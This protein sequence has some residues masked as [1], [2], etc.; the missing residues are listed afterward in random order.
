MTVYIGYLMLMGIQ[1]W[2]FTKNDFMFTAKNKK[3]FLILCC[4]ELILLAAV[5]GYTV[6]ADTRTYLDALEY[7]SA[8]PKKE[9]LFAKLLW[10]YSFEPG[11]FLFTKICAFLSIPKPLFLLLVAVVI[12]VPVFMNMERYSEL[13]YISI[14][15]YFGM[16]F[17]AYSLG[18]FRQ[19]MAVSIILCGLKFIEQK[20]L[21]KYLVIVAIATLFHTTAIA[22]VALY[23]AAQCPLKKYVK[24]IIPAEV[25]F[26]VFGRQFVMLLV[27]VFP[28]Y[29]S[30]IGGIKD[31]QGG[32][33]LMLIL[34][35]CILFS[36]IYMEHKG[37]ITRKLN[38]SALTIAVM[39]QAISY[40]MVLMGRAAMYFSIFSIF[41]FSDIAYVMLCKPALY[42]SLKNDMLSLL[43][44]GTALAQKYRLKWQ[45]ILL[46]LIICC[47]GFL[48]LWNLVGNEYVTPYYLFFQN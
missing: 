15:A 39:V 27:S 1:S 6:G 18:I 34:M 48:V 16:G 29:A 17:F 11:Y 41:A 22:A 37:F 20:Q 44:T 4:L 24:W 46:I 26:V 32:T 21:I 7:Y 45:I 35:N 47:L 31:V 25:V 40:S 19:M 2:F 5:R 8:M 13:P 23:F 9:V 33:Y 10:P 38:I 28:R 30:Y 42:V 14:L 3:K 12:Y 43:R 36:L